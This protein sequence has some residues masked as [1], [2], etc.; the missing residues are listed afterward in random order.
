MVSNNDKKL[1]VFS[2]L[3]L[4][5]S[6][7]G[8]WQFS[9]YLMTNTELDNLSKINPITQVIMIYLLLFMCLLAL[10][11]IGLLLLSL[12][13]HIA[14][15]RTPA[16]LFINDDQLP[17]I[18]IIIPA[19][20]ESLVINQSIESL[21]NLDY[22]HYEV[23]VIDDGSMDDTSTKALHIKCRTER[24]RLRI[25]RKTNQGKA[26][27]LNTGLAHAVGDFILNVDADAILNK[28]ALR[29]CIRHFKDQRVGAV[30]GNIKIA[31]RTHLLTNIQA[32][33]YMESIAMVRR[34][35][36]F[37]GAINIIPGP[38]GMFRRQALNDA[39]G[40]SNDTFAEDCDLTLQLHQQGWR[41]RYEPNALSMT[42]APITLIAL[43]RQRY[44]WTRGILQAMRKN[45]WVLWRPISMKLN[46]VIL[47]YML[48]EGIL[49]PVTNVF[50]HLLFIVFGFQ[51]NVPEL[52]IFWW[53]Q[54]T[55]LDASAA[56]YCIVLEKEDTKI[57]PY[58][59]FLRP[60][61]LLIDV[62]K[63]FASLEEMGKK[64]MTW[65]KVPREGKL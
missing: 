47:W 17:F 40:Y 18:S 21:L 8:Y 59:I 55:A 61:S 54:L 4:F 42:E 9:R 34:A 48:F 10:R 33:E 12:P 44:R 64:P 7:L 26:D 38:L 5:I 63:L 20:N 31:N 41:V 14:Y 57:M 50:G 16:T 62:V 45:K 51:Y 19:Y 3:T 53:I 27:A 56:I 39:G 37:I 15:L 49:W 28:S 22:P 29:Y 2:L 13:E 43:L 36:S 1:I 58:V 52:V 24:V 60:Y 11:Y 6:A 65:N 25:I 30:A 23:L 32:L 46:S 35:Q